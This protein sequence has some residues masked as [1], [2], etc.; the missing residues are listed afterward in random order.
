VELF[1]EL[2]GHKIGGGPCDPSN[3]SSVGA[4]DPWHLDSPLIQFSAGD[5]FTL[6][7]AVE[8]VAIFGEL[9]AAKRMGSAVWLLLKYLE[10]R[11]GSPYCHPAGLLR[12]RRSSP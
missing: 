1:T 11:M 3:I 5:V 4:H 7:N 10:L 12:L 2:F 9:G 6:R 8:S